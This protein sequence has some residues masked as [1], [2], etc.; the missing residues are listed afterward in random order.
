MTC[1]LC[2]WT[3]Q[4]K[5]WTPPAY[6]SSK[7]RSQH[8]GKLTSRWTQWPRQTFLRKFRKFS[9]DHNMATTLDL[10]LPLNILEDICSQQLKTST[11]SQLKKILQ[12][13][14][15]NFE[16]KTVK[17]QKLGFELCYS[18]KTS[19]SASI[20]KTSDF[21]RNICKS[22]KM[23]IHRIYPSASKTLQFWEW[24]G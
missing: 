2:F 11:L 18:W 9:F 13:R 10:P 16:K 24:A 5:T 6:F 4:L 22:R 21:P 19:A 14:Q 7:I 12:Q 3:L 15:R 8:L 1:E 20:S 23:K 17:Q